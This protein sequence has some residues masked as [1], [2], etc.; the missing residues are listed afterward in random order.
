MDL[1]QG[2]EKMDDPL[3]FLTILEQALRQP[4]PRRSLEEAFAQII[5]MGAQGPYAEGLSNFRDFMDVACSH[6]DTVALD[7]ARELI[8]ELATGAFATQEQEAAGLKVI[9]SHPAWNA[10]YEEMQAEQAG[11]SPSR[12]SVPVIGVFGLEVK[13]GEMVF[14]RGVR[15]ASVGSISPGVCVLKLLNTGL[16]LWEGELAARDLIWTAA[17]GDRALPLAAQTEGGHRRPTREWVL[18]GRQMV[19]RTFAGIE[20]GTIELELTR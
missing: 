16:V 17:Y 10:E 13:I 8:A 15:R 14:E 5:R 12:E 1:A 18:P 7:A 4:E 2:G 11:Q 3:Y 19:L 20:K 9:E 6:A